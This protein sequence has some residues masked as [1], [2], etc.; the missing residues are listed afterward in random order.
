MDSAWYTVQA[1]PHNEDRVVNHLAKRAIPTFLPLVEVVRRRNGVRRTGVEPLFPGYLFVELESFDQRPGC[2]DVVRWSP[3]VRRILGIAEEPVPVPAAA[4]RA[5]RDRMQDLG[6]VRPGERFRPGDRVRFRTGALD[7][8]EAI[9]DRPASR[10]GRVH[11]L[12]ALLGSMRRVEA[13]EL[14]L[15]LA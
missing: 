9:L 6:F 1:K 2:W 10:A 7:G 8:L 5:I 13:D 3:G 12:L 15:E 14:D 4:I 11:V